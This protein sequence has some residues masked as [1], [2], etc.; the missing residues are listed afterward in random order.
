MLKGLYDGFLILGYQ[1]SSAAAQPLQHPSEWHRTM[2]NHCSEPR[3]V[4]GIR[5]GDIKSEARSLIGYRLLT[6]AERQKKALCDINSKAQNKP[7]Y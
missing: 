3:R 2:R 5:Y 6:L 7:L 4:V 1:K